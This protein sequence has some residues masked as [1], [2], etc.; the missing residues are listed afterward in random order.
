MKASLGLL[1]VLVTSVGQVFADTPDNARKIAESSTAQWNEAFAKGK[2]DDILTLYSDDAM[3]LQPD[4][5]VSKGSSQIRDFW[6]KMIK[7]GEYA[8]DVID[9]RR[10]HSGTIVAT[11]RFSDVKTL[12]TANQT[13]KY[14]Y[15]GVV[16]SVLK[17]QADGSW[18]AEVQRWNSAH[19]T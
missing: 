14:N 9:L 1:F 8:M 3:L 13:V 11:V 2:V 7:Q 4:G 16:Y 12:S 6:Q 18:K 10:E 5:A 15:D 17:Q 19:N